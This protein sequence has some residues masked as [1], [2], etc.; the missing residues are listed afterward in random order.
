MMAQLYL[1]AVIAFCLGWYCC[2]LFEEDRRQ[3]ERRDREAAQDAA[4]E[5]D[6]ALQVLTHHDPQIR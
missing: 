6:L 4:R 2:L 1:A 3:D 5:K